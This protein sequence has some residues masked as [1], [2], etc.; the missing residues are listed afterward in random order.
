MKRVSFVFLMLLLIVP[1]YAL[2][3]EVI[4]GETSQKTLDEVVVTATKTE[5]KRKDI[6]N[7][8]ITLDAMD[9]Q[10]SSATSLGDLLGNELGID[11]RTR[12]DYGGAAEEIH[13][14]GMGADG[15]QILINGVVV[16][17][18][19]LG[20][21]DV[22]RIPLNNIARIEV[23]KGP[24]SLLY[25]TSAMGGIVNII[26]KR[27]TEDKMDL[28]LSA[29][30]GSDDTY[31]IAAEQG[32]FVGGGFGYYL[33]TTWRDT[34][35]FR[36][37]ADLDHKDV[38]LNLVYDRGDVLNISLY[39]D[40]IDREFGR[41]GAETPDGT[42][43][44]LHTPTGEKLYDDESANLLNSGGDEDAHLSLSIKSSPLQW[45]SWCLK[46]SYMDM[47]SYNYN[48]YYSSFSGTLPGS[49]TWVTNEVHG[50]EGNVDIKPFDGFSLLL[51]GE[52]KAYDWKNVNI[53]LNGIGADSGKATA[54]HDLHSSGVFS[55]AQY[56]P[57]RFFKAVIGLRREYHSEFGS[58]YIPRYGIIVNPFETTALKFNHGKH[59]NAPTPNDLFWPME[60]WGWGSGVQGNS[61]LEPETG[62]HTDVTIE[63]SLFQN[64][65]FINISYYRWTISDKIEWVDVGSYFYRPQNL[66]K[67]NAD[68]WEFGTK[69]GPFYDLSLGL[70]Y[71]LNDAYEK[72]AG[73]VKRQARYTPDYTF[74][75]DLSYWNE[76]GL[77]ATATIRYTGDRPGYYTDVSDKSSQVVLA[78]YWTADLKIEQRLFENW[79]LSLQCNN[80]S[81]KEYFTY[82]ENFTT[83]SGSSTMAEYPG[84]GRSVYFNVTFEY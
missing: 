11:W 36:N 12:G 66:N 60:D 49:K 74:K 73:G 30:Y 9:I 25:G 64:K 82:T 56:R 27:P 4:E 10:E 61:N 72:Q 43:T 78:D 67:Y 63:Q 16:N 81:N 77:T 35:G 29:G 83:V 70:S 62:R 69:I 65:W 24:G 38:S 50:V 57:C 18:P 40:Y 59:F 33:T 53:S 42:S 41:P 3:E 45:L 28:S 46:G 68:G 26:T 37:N 51:G 23:V 39:G 1:S 8:V 76:I 14:R 7:S 2:S 58:E 55:E 84:A 15:T 71:T 31:E 44:Y 22:G 34:D 54:N 21:A 79:L 13:I 47:E 6:P 32:M 5:E 52:Y 80:L 20:T 75:G 17:S 19:S 48:R